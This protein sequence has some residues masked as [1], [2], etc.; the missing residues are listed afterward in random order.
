QMSDE[1]RTEVNKHFDANEGIE[2]SSNH[3][4]KYLRP[5]AQTIRMQEKIL[6]KVD[7]FPDTNENSFNVIVVN[8]MEFHFGY[9]DADDARNVVYGKPRK[10]VF[11]EYWGGRIKGLLE[12]DNP[13]KG[14]NLFRQRIAATLFI[15]KIHACNLLQD[16][17]IVC[18]TTLGKQYVDLFKESIESIPSASQI[19]WIESNTL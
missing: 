3:P 14:A 8:C 10:L 9:F 13:N 12:K 18:N 16:S 17:L 5:E 19:K 2:L 7:K 11:T 4:N 6:D 15:P 1:L